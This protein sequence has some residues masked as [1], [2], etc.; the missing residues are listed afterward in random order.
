MQ[1]LRRIAAIEILVQNMMEAM[2]YLHRRVNIYFR[3][4][5]MLSPEKLIWKCAKS[6]H[7]DTIKL[8]GFVA[9]YWRCCW[10]IIERG[11]YSWTEKPTRVR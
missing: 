3:Y 1:F 10:T 2:I 7:I 8:E 6:L 9:R 11:D 4:I 5:D